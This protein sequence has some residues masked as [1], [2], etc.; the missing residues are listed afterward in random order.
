MARPDARP[1]SRWHRAMPG[2]N[3]TILTLLIPPTIHLEYILRVYT[4]FM[5]AS[6]AGAHARHDRGEGPVSAAAGSAMRQNAHWPV[7]YQGRCCL[8]RI[9]GR[10]ILLRRRRWPARDGRALMPRRWHGNGA[11]L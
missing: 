6:R 9:S 2:R 3:P 5:T 10:T 7:L 11:E 4:S 8:L 1:G